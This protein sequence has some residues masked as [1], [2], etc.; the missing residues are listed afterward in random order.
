MK[1]SD[2]EGPLLDYWVA[3]AEG[4]ELRP[5][6]FMQEDGLV[7]A[8]PVDQPTSRRYCPSRNWAHGGQIIE[9]EGIAVW[10][11]N[12][13]YS[14]PDHG[15][16]ALHPSARGGYSGDCHYID[17]RQDDCMFGTTPLI[18]AMRALVASKF[19]EEVPE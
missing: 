13:F 9:R 11:G 19:G 4:H 1:V 7:Y 2:L 6:E 18:A 17:V 8:T 10:R 16:Y 12:V 3:R 14:R 15:W 5:D